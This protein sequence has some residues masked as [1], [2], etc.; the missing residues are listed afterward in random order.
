MCKESG[1]CAI[2]A[3]QLRWAWDSQAHSLSLLLILGR[4]TYASSCMK[5][6]VLGQQSFLRT[7]GG[8]LNATVCGIVQ[9]SNH[10]HSLLRLTAST[11]ADTNSRMANDRNMIFSSSPSKSAKPSLFPLPYSRLTLL[12][13]IHT[14]SIPMMRSTFLHPLLCLSG[15]LWHMPTTL[16]TG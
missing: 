8:P 3:V 1:V 7:Q 10:S 6:Y 11:V 4:L 5:K 16:H 9:L 12:I 13:S 14:V 15:P 2:K